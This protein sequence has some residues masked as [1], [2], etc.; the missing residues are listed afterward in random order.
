MNIFVVCACTR[1]H[2]VYGGSAKIAQ[3]RAGSNGELR[4]TRRRHA[5]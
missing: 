1:L 2:P 5:N 3:S 4:V